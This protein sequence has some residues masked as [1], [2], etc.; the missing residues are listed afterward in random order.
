MEEEVDSVACAALIAEIYIEPGGVPSRA[1]HAELERATLYFVSCS[2]GGD[3][4]LHAGRAGYGKGRTYVKGIRAVVGGCHRTDL[5]IDRP[6]LHLQ[7]LPNHQ[8][9]RCVRHCF[10]AVGDV[11]PDCGGNRCT[12]RDGETSVFDTAGSHE[13]ENPD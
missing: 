2:A 8:Q 9:D 12:R 11:T 4:Q 3:L 13:Q 10:T 7:I 5:G 6:A 1:A